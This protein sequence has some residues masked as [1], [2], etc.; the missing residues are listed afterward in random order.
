M[1]KPYTLRRETWRDK[2]RGRFSDNQKDFPAPEELADKREKIRGGTQ[3]LTEKLAI[4]SEKADEIAE[5]IDEALA[6]I[7]STEDLRCR[8]EGLVAE[9]E[10]YLRSLDNSMDNLEES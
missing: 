10:D 1:R 3:V 6:N 9:A 8:A 7:E 5:S 2:V 4:V